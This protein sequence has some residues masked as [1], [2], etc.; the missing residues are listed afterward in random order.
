MKA[1]VGFDFGEKK[2]ALQ[3]GIDKGILDKDGNMVVTAKINFDTSS[4]PATIAAFTTPQ[5]NPDGSTAT[6]NV[7]ITPTIDTSSVTTQLA[8][9]STTVGEM[10]PIVVPVTFDDAAAAASAKNTFAQWANGFL[11]PENVSL[12]GI[13]FSTSFANSLVEQAP[14]FNTIGMQTGVYIYNGFVEHGTGAAIVEELATQLMAAQ[15]GIESA[16]LSTGKIWGETFLSIIKGNVPLQLVNILT[17][18]VTPEVIDAI[19]LQQ[20][21]TGAN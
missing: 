15:S 13:M 11:N 4:Y 21:Q 3:P 14:A 5:K 20:T 19:R 9:L 8:D 16:A 2:D 17:D 6:N 18:L 7:A 10:N 12:F 1:F